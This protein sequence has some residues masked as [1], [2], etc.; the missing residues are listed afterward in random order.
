MRWISAFLII[1]TAVGCEK[2]D[3]K[4]LGGKSQPEPD[5]VVAKGSHSDRQPDAQAPPAKQPE[6]QKEVMAYVNGTPVYMGR[7]HDLLVLAGGRKMARNI[8]AW[9]LVDQE[10]ENRAVTVTAKD[11][12][13]EHEA[14]LARMFPQVTDTADRENLLRQLM[15]REAVS[16][17]QW[18]MSMRMQAQLTKIL[19]PQIEVTAEEM[20]QAFAD[21]Y[22]R[23]VVVRHIQSASLEDAEDALRQL[24][25][26][27]DFAQLARKVSKHTSATDGGLLPPVSAKAKILPRALHKAAWSMSTVGQISGPIQAGTS[28]HL[29]YLEKVIE[30]QNVAFK[31]VTDE[32]EAVVKPG[33]MRLVEPQ[34]VASKDV[35]DELEAVVKRSKMRLAK[36]RFLQQKIADADIKWVDPV[37][38]QS[39]A[40]PSGQAQIG[41]P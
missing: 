17:K 6:G 30:R 18:R 10:A 3:L 39:D 38:Q 11:I 2:L 15:V 7:L 34:N 40:R 32:L 35:T 27:A 4:A 14:T 19:A 23:K 33:K 8:V 41:Q 9:E 26:G 1:A 24:K 31:D 13:V 25:A 22:G 36:E 5:P 28:Y 21:E 20:Q 16:K 12:D 29:L 37:L